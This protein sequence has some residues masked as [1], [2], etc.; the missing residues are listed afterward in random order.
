MHG[1][2]P[3]CNFQFFSTVFGNKC[4]NILKSVID[5]KMV[6]LL[7]AYILSVPV[8]FISYTITSTNSV[9]SYCLLAM[10][11][12]THCPKTEWMNNCLCH[13]DLCA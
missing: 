12:S 9:S 3:T 13:D 5:A 6:D 11:G 2:E 1:N 4:I 8:F 10:R 7:C